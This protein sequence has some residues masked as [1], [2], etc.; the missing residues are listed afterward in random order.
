MT[1]EQIHT[2]IYCSE[3]KKITR[4]PAH[5]FLDVWVAF[6]S[7]YPPICLLFSTPLRLLLVCCFVRKVCVCVPFL[8]YFKALF[9]LRPKLPDNDWSL[10]NVCTHHRW[11]M[12]K[13]LEKCIF[14]FTL[15]LYQTSIAEWTVTEPRYKRHFGLKKATIGWQVNDGRLTGVNIRVC[16]T[17]RN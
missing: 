5:S 6:E 15:V 3:S 12:L 9:Y 10:P 16:K 17:V 13:P 14:P 7:E 1:N 8:P 11:Q 4:S 2:H